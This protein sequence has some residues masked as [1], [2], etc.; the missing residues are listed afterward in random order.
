MAEY[1]MSLKMEDSIKHELDVEY[2]N[3]AEVEAT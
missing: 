2:F 1:E 3:V